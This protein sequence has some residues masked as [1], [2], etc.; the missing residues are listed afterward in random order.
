MPVVLGD[1]NCKSPLTAN[2]Q[3]T[4][5]A[6]I[7]EI[8]EITDRLESVTGSTKD[9]ITGAMISPCGEKCNAPDGLLD[10]LRYERGKLGAVLQTAQEV[11]DSIY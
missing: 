4:A 7:M 2:Q 5:S 6:I 1:C 10:A 8:I 9:H 3:E 11:R